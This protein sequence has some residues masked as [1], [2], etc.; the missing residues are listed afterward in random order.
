MSNLSITLTPY[1]QQWVEARVA[2][3][4][5]TNV[6]EVIREAVRLLEQ[7]EQEREAR[8]R[9]LRVEETIRELHIAREKRQT[10]PPSTA[11]SLLA[12]AG[13]WVGDDLE[14]CL[15]SVYAT[16]TPLEG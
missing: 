14:E 7:H 10:P 13:S 5:Y 8:L 16:R 1:L 9:D 12:F 4:R 3:G 6:S 2:S 11:E 15:A